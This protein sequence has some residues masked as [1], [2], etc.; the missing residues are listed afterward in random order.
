MRRALERRHLACRGSAG[1]THACFGRPQVR[2][3]EAGGGVPGGD[4]ENSPHMT[5]AKSNEIRV[6]FVRTGQ[7]EWEGAGRIAGATDVP[8]SSAGRDE[9]HQT[10]AHLGPVHLSTI[11]CSTDE[12]SVTTAEE[13]SRLTGGKVRQI[14]DLG[15]INLGLWEGLLARELEEKCPRAYRQ[16]LDDPSLVQVPDGESLEEARQRLVEALAQTLDKGRWGNGAVAVVLRPLALGLVACALADA[17]NSSL[18]TMMKSGLPAEWH[19]LQRGV[20]RNGR[21]QARAGT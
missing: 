11:Y 19:T 7:T 4:S 8:L 13:L 21:T 6:L 16:W 2:D 18:W 14:E 20:L 3:V 10:L 1:Y 15:E 12:A 9:I 5:M 17:P